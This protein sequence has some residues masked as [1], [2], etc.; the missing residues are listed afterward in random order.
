MTQISAHISS[1]TKKRIDRYVRSTGSTR[2]YV[3]EQALMHHL[4]ALEE[5]PIDIVIPARIVLTKDSAEK[6]RNLTSHPPAPTEAMK[7]LFDDR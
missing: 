1:E 5:L 4:R 2:G 7:Q 6:V 3:I